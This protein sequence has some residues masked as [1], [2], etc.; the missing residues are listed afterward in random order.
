[1]RLGVAL[2]S[3]A[4]RGFTHIGVLR[5]LEAAGYRPEVVCGSSMG[6]FVA[7]A[8]ASG[9]LDRF[10]AFA[11]GLDRNRVL[12]FFD[13]SFRGGLIQARRLFQFL[14]EDMPD[15][16]IGALPVRFGA[17]AT[18]LER[19]HEVWLRAGSLHEAIRAS[20][21]LPGLVAPVRVD[22]RWLTDG[23][24]VNPI[25]VALCRALGAD[26]VVAV[27]IEAAEHPKFP[28]P[29]E[30]GEPADGAE[31]P[32][33]TPS[34]IE[35]VSQVVHVMQVRVARHRLAGEPPEL[36]VRPQLGHVGL[37]DFH[38]A[39]EAIDEGRRALRAALDARRLIS[40]T[41]GGDAVPGLEPES[42]VEPDRPEDDG[43][44]GA[45]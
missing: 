26:V 32:S 37:L 7:G 44:A 19:G 23:G 27:D 6:A 8:Y 45:P 28:E 40:R 25:P 39:G 12:A 1:M 13:F 35:V 16:D 10:E 14:S 17:V 22:G 4:A 24:V 43:E 11:R 2:G 21:A 20:I 42:R 5:E 36:H 18:E 41:P 29:A 15:R 34:M 9:H 3:G 30:L 33:R 38:R 31:D